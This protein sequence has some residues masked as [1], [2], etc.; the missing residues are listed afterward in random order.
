[1]LAEGVD[2]EH[3]GMREA[4]HR[5]RLLREEVVHVREAHHRRLDE[6][7]GDAT[8]QS[9]VQRSR[10]DA[11]AADT[12]HALDA[13]GPTD[14]RPE[15]DADVRERIARSAQRRRFSSY[16][17][18]RRSLRADGDALVRRTLRAH[19]E[20]LPRVSAADADS[21]DDG[22]SRALYYAPAWG[23]ERVWR[24]EGRE[25]GVSLDEVTLRERAAGTPSR[26]SSRPPRGRPS[27]TRSLAPSTKPFR[28]TV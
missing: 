15:R 17:P 14:Q 23:R 5:A 28:V 13:I 10:D 9:L 24:T 8:L 7:D 22:G 19:V 18:V 12:E 4:R 3:V 20:T 2:G 21:D 6:L 25:A 11:H 1:M 16:R 26:R 27:R